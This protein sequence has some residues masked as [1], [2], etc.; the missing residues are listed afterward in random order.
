M[1]SRVKI[2][3]LNYSQIHRT[4]ASMGIIVAPIEVVHQDLDPVPESSDVGKL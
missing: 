4:E 3:V 1:I 2:R